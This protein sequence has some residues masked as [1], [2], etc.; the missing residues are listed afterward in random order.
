MVY[1]ESGRCL[2]MRYSISPIHV[3]RLTFLISWKNVEGEGL[4]HAAWRNWANY[5]LVLF[6]CTMT[7]AACACGRIGVS[8]MFH[9]PYDML[10]LPVIIMS[11]FFSN[12]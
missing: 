2:E 5:V 12:I 4:N 3:V 9:R 6:I 1:G 11:L 8:G 7:L 10:R